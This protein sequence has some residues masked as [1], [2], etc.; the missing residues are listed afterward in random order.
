MVKILFFSPFSIL[1]PTFQTRSKKFFMN[2]YNFYLSLVHEKLSFFAGLEDFWQNLD[3]IYGND[4]DAVIAEALRS[5]WVKGDFSNLPVIE[6]VSADI[7]ESAWGGYGASNNT[8]YLCESLLALGSP[9]LI[10]A[11]LLEEIG[12]Y[13]DALVNAVDTP[14]D[15]GELFALRVQGIAI[16]GAQL[17]RMKGD[18]DSGT[19]TVNGEKVA[20]EMA[21]GRIISTVETT[22]NDNLKFESIGTGTGAQNN[23]ILITTTGSISST[24]TGT[25]TVIGQGSPDGTL[26]NNM[27]VRIEGKITS[28]NGAIFVDG[29]AGAG[30]QVNNG[31]LVFNGGVISS[32]GIGDNAATI[33]INGQGSSKSTTAGNEGV[34]VDGIGSQITSVDGAISITGIGGSGTDVNG[35]VV[36]FNGGV[37]SSTGTDKNAATI[38]INGQGS[39]NASGPGNSGVR[40]DGSGSTIISVEGAVSITGTGGSGTNVNEGV[41]LS[42]GGQIIST[43]TGD[44]AATITING[45]G[46]TTASGAGN[47]GARVT[48][49]NSTITSVNGAITIK[50][51]G[52]SGTFLNTGVSVGTG[53]V[54]SSTGT[55]ANA[56]TITIE[57]KGSTT[58]TT[59]NNM[60]VRIGETD[61]N[62]KITS[63]D[64]AI[65]ITG[66]GG[67][68]TGSN[69]GVSVLNNVFVSSTGKGTITIIG[70]GGNGSDGNHGV[71]VATGGV[72]SS[73]GSGAD[74]GTITINGQGSTTA[75]GSLNQGVRINAASITSE[76]GA[77]TINGTG[78]RNRYEYWRSFEQRCVHCIHW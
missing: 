44:N 25:I 13:V 76:D 33:T 19:I 29:T 54:I 27:G 2:T 56:A 75:T 26:E 63:V 24:G 47:H 32:T 67:S 46:S 45:Q 61:P 39:T 40:I 14:G 53:G 35:G 11:V 21:T 41:T 7:L 23:G 55:G 65:S 30:T 28:I 4:Y 20:I 51:T 3:L 73:T 38:T 36:V 1:H 60:G 66:T 57:G 49:A 43:G 16:D 37:I 42:N 8:I 15:E 72:I 70:T 22:I 74:A 5:S 12:H 50:G 48:G 9:E 18:D 58:A 6:V 59:I 31:V 52:G 10:V 78:E 62:G 69:F 77:I 34:R 64:G 17:E 68:G 71:F